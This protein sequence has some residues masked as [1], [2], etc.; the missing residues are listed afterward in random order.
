MARVLIVDDDL[1]EIVE[2]RS[3]ITLDYPET[4]IITL[5]NGK[6]ALDYIARRVREE[7]PPDLVLMD[8]QLGGD[9]SGLE[10]TKRMR[11]LGYQNPIYLVTNFASIEELSYPGINGTIYRML[12]VSDI[13]RQY[14]HAHLS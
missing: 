9:I 12:S 7:S 14:L 3:R 13:C 10:T 4:E 11:E 2:F 1:G 5:S 6:S 8:L